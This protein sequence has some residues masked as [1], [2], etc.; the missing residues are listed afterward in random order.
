MGKDSF[1]R[2]IEL[3]LGTLLCTFV[4]ILVGRGAILDKKADKVSLDEYI[5]RQSNLDRLER[6][7]IDN[8]LNNMETNY[9][10]RLLE[11]QKQTQS[12]VEGIHKSINN[13]FEDIKDLIKASK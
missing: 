3:V 13:R 12:Y 4:I 1:K 6:L 2:V 10:K 7:R 8:E 11:Q 5:L 9:N